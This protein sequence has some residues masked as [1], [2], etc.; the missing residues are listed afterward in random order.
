MTCAKTGFSGVGRGSQTLYG[1]PPKAKVV[2]KGAAFDFS[3]CCGSWEETRSDDGSRHLHLC[4]RAESS[5]S[6]PFRHVSADRLW[7]E[8]YGVET[9]RRR[10]EERDAAPTAD[11]FQESIRITAAQH[12]APEQIE[13]WAGGV[14]DLTAWGARRTA[15]WTVVAEA[16]G[17]VV[18]FRRTPCVL[19]STISATGF[20]LR[21]TGGLRT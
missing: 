12:Y 8:T 13:A 14:I 4:E 15:A 17:K 18:G 3:C 21:R 16:D 11:L 7:W 5:R 2:P 19:T 9:A 10:Y 20:W 6:R 1:G